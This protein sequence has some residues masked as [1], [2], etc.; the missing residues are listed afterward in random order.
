M[1]DNTDRS[2]HAPRFIRLTSP[3]TS[4]FLRH[5]APMGPNTVLTVRGRK[6]GR[7]LDVPV[8][9]VELDHRLW[10]L[11]AYGDVNWVRNLRVA[12]E[13]DVRIKGHTQHVTAIEL[14]QA[15]ATS[16]FRD[17]LYP[18]VDRLP[19]LG[20]WFGHLLFRLVA[21]ELLSDPAAAARKRPVFELTPA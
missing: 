17:R 21:P 2:T 18:Y 12:G 13:A 3:L 14:D 5:G 19:R 11:G 4:F 20:R 8:A 7:M 9:V 10:V 6:S 16:F 15:Q 1:N